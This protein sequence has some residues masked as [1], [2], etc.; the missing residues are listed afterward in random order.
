VFDPIVII[1]IA[2]SSAL[3]SYMAVAWQSKN[4]H[5]IIIKTLLTI[6]SSIGYYIVVHYFWNI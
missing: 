1:Y 5:N 4:S 2:F 6:L 3:M